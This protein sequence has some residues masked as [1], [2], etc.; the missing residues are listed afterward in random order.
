MPT[1]FPRIFG[2][3]PSWCQAKNL[4]KS[5]HRLMATPAPSMNAPMAAGYNPFATDP[6]KA[7]KARLNQQHVP[8]DVFKDSKTLAV[9][10]P[11]ASLATKQTEYAKPFFDRVLGAQ[12]WQMV[13]VSR[14]CTGVA[15][16]LV[17]I[18]LFDARDNK[19]IQETTSD[20]GG[21]W[22]MIVPSVGPFFLVE[23]KEGSPDV[24]G[25]SANDLT[26]VL[27]PV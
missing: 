25:T 16:G 11:A 20:A 13:G 26:P 21:D 8:G 5:N 9:V 24:A 14:D 22:S 27:I 15:I 12:K 4:F 7:Y 19:F 1:S 23:Y 6:G 2:N 10:N 17:R 3:V 18:M